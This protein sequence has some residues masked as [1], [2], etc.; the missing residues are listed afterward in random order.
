[1]A[2]LLL[3]VSQ[4]NLRGKVLACFIAEEE[5]Q[6]FR[7]RLSLAALADS[8]Q[9][10]ETRLQ[11]RHGPPLIV[12]LR[13][14]ASRGYDGKLS[15]LQ[16]LVRDIAK[17]KEAEE[18]LRRSHQDLEDRIKQ[19]TAEL[20]KANEELR[21]EVA[22]RKQA[23][24][25]L[26]ENQKQLASII[27]SAMDAIITVDS[28][29]RIILYNAAAER[30]FLCP[31][32]RAIGQSLDRFIPERFRDSYQEHIRRLGEAGITP[33]SMGKI[34]TISGLRADGKEFPIEVSISQV[35]AGSKKLLTVIIRDVTR[36]VR[37]EEKLREQAAL[38]DQA[39]DAIMV[40]D[41]EDRVLFWNKGAERIYGWSAEEAAGK[42]IRDL[43]Y[44]EIGQDYYEAK[45]VL[46]ETGYWSGEARHV[47]KS[48]NVIV[49]ENRWTLLC[50]QQ[51]NPER[52]LVI[53]TD[54]TEKKKL[55]E[56]FLRAQRMESIGMLAAGI[57]HDLG[58]ILSPMLMAVQLLRLNFD[59]T[60]K[61]SLLSI[62]E[63]NGLRGAEL[64][65][66]ILGFARGI[67]GG[68]IILQL[69][70]VIKDIET[71][72]KETFPKSI[73]FES[74]LPEDLW[75]IMGDATQL[76]QVLMNL[77]INARDAMPRGGLL[78]ISAENIEIDQA[79]AD[80]LG[81]LSPGR[82]ILVKVADTGSGIPAQNLNRMFEPFFT[83]K[84]PGKGSGL[85]L[86]CVVEIMKSHKGL[87][88]V[89]SKE[90]IGTEFRLYLP[91]AEATS[92][93]Q[94][95]SKQLNLHVGCGQKILIVDDE[96]TIL[97]ITRKTLEAH[98]YSVMTAGDGAEAISL[99]A[100]Y[101]DEIDLIIMDML[102][103]F[104][105]GPATIRSLERIDPKV[106]IIISS[107]YSQSI[108]EIDSP[109]VKS[110]LVKPYPAQMLLRVLADALAE[111]SGGRRRSSDRD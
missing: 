42:H 44:K 107:A 39:P 55:E 108:D 78:T 104:M 79:Y 106:K 92:V 98:G 63:K 7:S 81:K 53:N 68:P 65:K 13:V 3:K 72:I 89:D 76:H 85:G 26:R 37:D 69:R 2:A 50:D 80:A 111:S 105:D 103:P 25:A 93:L 14:A 91:A 51:D 73:A 29:L 71:V 34:R 16:W 40:R 11:P 96:A 54:I 59:P 19:Q 97:E 20:V 58:N 57:A 1:A 36:H 43:Q 21:I 18:A 109:A 30:M 67:E 6:A 46:M 28:D 82:Y 35:E 49:A 100:Q 95:E 94:A 70:H 24:S 32:S 77:C 17:Q 9:E 23:E 33:R 10:W 61:E 110:V 99:F 8:I 75:P 101:K 22:E 87:I 83:T 56:Q 31:A 62:I 74:H 27:E 90:G 60:G 45:R 15:S 38:I 4:E 12:A 88:D 86:T 52:I 48:G 102:M 5:R 41:L 84:E 47:T 64:L 66:Q